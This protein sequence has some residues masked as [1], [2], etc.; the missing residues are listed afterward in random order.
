MV[1][2]SFIDGGNWYIRENNRSMLIVSIKGDYAIV[3]INTH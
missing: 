2:V 1:E 3:D